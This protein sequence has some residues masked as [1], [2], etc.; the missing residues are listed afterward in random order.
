MN[1]IFRT[2]ASRL[3]GSGHVMRCLTLAKALKKMRANVTFISRAHDGNLNSFIADSG[4]NII[5]LDNSNLK[6]TISN[7]SGYE[8]W[9]GTDQ[10]TDAKACIEKLHNIKIDWLIIDHYALDQ[11]W[12]IQLSTHCDK[13]L[14]ID[15]MA[16]RKHFCDVLLD[17]NFSLKQ[18]RYE[19]LLPEKTIKLIGPQYALLDP[20]YSKVNH[21]KLNS[22]KLI[23]NLLVFFGGGDLFD[24][25]SKT[26]EAL[27]H[28]NFQQLKVDIVIGTMNQNRSQIE[29]L[30]VHQKNSTL[31]VQTKNMAELIARADLAIAAAGTNTW[32]RLALGLPSIVITTAE[33]QYSVIQDLSKKQYV[34]WIGDANQI[35]SKSIQQHLQQVLD[36]PKELIIKSLKGQQLIN[37]NGAKTVAEILQYINHKKPSI[38]SAQR[39]SIQIIS[40]SDSWMNDWIKELIVTWSASGH[41]VRWRHHFEDLTQG[42]YCFLLSFSSIISETTLTLNQHNFVVHASDLPAGKG[43]SPLSWQILEGKNNIKVSLFEAQT[44]LDSG[45]IYLQKSLNFTGHELLPEMQQSLAALT[46]EL[47]LKIVNNPDDIFNNAREQTGTESH[48]K[49]RS[50]VDSQLDPGKNIKEQFNLL[51]IVDNEK[52]PA[53]FKLHGKKYTLKIERAD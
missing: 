35:T 40:D 29:S 28:K 8:Q 44:A 26:I 53:F 24:L 23:K 34:H 48:Y 43:M 52:Y 25:T 6:N 16:N 2:D 30:L 39:K 33:N 42:D 17:Q 21:R 1:C 51:R 15:D 10:Q 4:F 5:A 11:E 18:D 19:A 41:T 36:N 45:R 38:A 46:L 7:L 3:I 49:R 22:N 37:K 9:L 12:E 20:S 50:P 14:V 27:S 47:C 13:I 32:E 31:H